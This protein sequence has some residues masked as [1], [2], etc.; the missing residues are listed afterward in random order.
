[1][2]LSLIR[3]ARTRITRFRASG[4]RLSISG[5]GQFI[6]GI[7]AATRVAVDPRAVADAG[8]RRYLRNADFSGMV[9]RS[10]V[11]QIARLELYPNRILRRL[12]SRHRYRALAVVN[13]E[14]PAIVRGQFRGVSGD[15]LTIRAT[16][17]GQLILRQ[18]VR[19]F[20]IRRFEARIHAVIV[21]AQTVYNQAFVNSAIQDII[22]LFRADP[23]R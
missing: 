2:P 12:S 10:T 1:M 6:Q 7:Q 20:A 4:G 11:N 14:L 13:R 3:L 17:V 18:R 5:I 9:G 23:I 16:H 8:I 15:V 22:N 21:A 19:P